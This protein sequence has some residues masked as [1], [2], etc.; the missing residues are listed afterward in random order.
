MN[1]FVT[2]AFFIQNHDIFI[3]FTAE[4]MNIKK[5]CY[6]L[7]TTGIEKNPARNSLTLAVLFYT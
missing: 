1:I 7:E 2:N 5:I 3:E 6:G 4:L